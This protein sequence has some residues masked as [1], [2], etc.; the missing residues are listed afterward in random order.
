MLKNKILDYEQVLNVLDKITKKGVIKKTNDI[1]K[2]EYKLP[3]EQYIVGSG[4]NHIVITGA[5]HGCEIITTDFILNLMILLKTI[6]T[7]YLQIKTI[8]IEI[9]SI[10][11]GRNILQNFSF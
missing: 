6:M 4:K 5:T 10:N 3:I 11:I 1:G 8:N 7:N 9:K 2:S